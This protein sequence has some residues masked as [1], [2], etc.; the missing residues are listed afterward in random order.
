MCQE[1]TSKSGNGKGLVSKDSY[2]NLYNIYIS[3]TKVKQI[4]NDFES[5]AAISNNR[6]FIIY[7]D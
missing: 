3:F 5:C 1:D 4:Y 2:S 7:K 6:R